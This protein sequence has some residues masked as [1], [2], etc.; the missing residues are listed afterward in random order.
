MKVRRNGKR[1]SMP[2]RNKDGSF[3]KRKRKVRRN[4]PFA[5]IKTSTPKST[6][7]KKSGGK[8]RRR[9]GSRITKAGA[10]GSKFVIRGRRMTVRRNPSGGML[11]GLKNII[12][13]DNLH[14]AGGVIGANVVNKFVMKSFGT[15]LPMSSNPYAN[16]AYR[17]LIPALASMAVRRFSSKLADGMVIGGVVAGVQGLITQ[18]MPTLGAYQAYVDAAP[19]PQMDYPTG[20]IMTPVTGSIDSGSRMNSSVSGFS[21]IYESPNPFNNDAWSN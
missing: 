17:V 3:R 4:T 14:L 18:F 6:M 5:A 9:S 13:R 15:S 16:V 20:S 1:R 19:Y 7:A 2:P 11:A 10:S 8:K 21:G 12:S